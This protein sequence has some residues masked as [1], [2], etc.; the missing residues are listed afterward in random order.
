MHTLRL[1]SVQTQ[2]EMAALRRDADHVRRSRNTVENERNGAARQFEL[3]LKQVALEL[4]DLAA[5]KEL[6][7]EQ[8]AKVREEN[9]HLK[10]TC[11]QLQA[12][13][14]DAEAEM[15]ELR[16]RS[17]D[18]RRYQQELKESQYQ[19]IAA[20]EAAGVLQ[21]QLLHPAGSHNKHE[22]EELT[23]SFKGFSI[24]SQI[25]MNIL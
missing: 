25:L 9:G 19:L 3:K 2:N 16:R 17:N 15:A 14:F 21:H 5:A 12:V 22:L 1:Q 6:V 10:R 8:L 18:S 7:D 13:L 11:Q 4:N 23:R 20:R 24:A